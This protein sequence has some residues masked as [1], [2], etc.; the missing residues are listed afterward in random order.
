M[1]PVVTTH[2]SSKPYSAALTVAAIL[3]LSS[4]WV[5]TII[6]I[7]KSD[8]GIITGWPAV[9][10]FSLPLISIAIATL[11]IPP[12]FRLSN[13][14][15]QKCITGGIYLLICFPLVLWIIGSFIF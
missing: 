11:A 4:F 10:R 13:S 12:L 14:I 1:T 6:E 3:S 5:P 15:L 7:I 9:A 2:K 8:E